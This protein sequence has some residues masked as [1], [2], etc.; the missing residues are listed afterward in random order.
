MQL[1]YN[2][3]LNE[4][5]TEHLFTREESKHIVKVLRKDIGDKLVITNGKGWI[6]KVRCVLLCHGFI[7]NKVAI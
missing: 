1:F 7:N 3:T 2:N 4:T 6:F 5:S